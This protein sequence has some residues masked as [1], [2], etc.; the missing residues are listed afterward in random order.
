MREDIKEEEQGK[1]MQG[2]LPAWAEFN[3]K[4]WIWD[5]LGEQGCQE[6]AD[7]GQEEGLHLEIATRQEK[8]E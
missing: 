2:E 1:E 6:G 3:M 8:S 5:H 4:G 7:G